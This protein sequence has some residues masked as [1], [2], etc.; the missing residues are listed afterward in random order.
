M[1][2]T[3]FY[4]LLLYRRAFQDVNLGYASAMAL[5]LLA[6]VLVLTVLLVR[7]SRNW[8]SATRQSAMARASRSL[9]PG[10]PLRI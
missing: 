7:S 2:R 10:R 6:V 4:V 5:V 8:V 9:G 1:N 3:L